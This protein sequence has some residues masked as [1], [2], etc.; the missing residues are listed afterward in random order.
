LNSNIIGG[1]LSS[2]NPTLSYQV[3]DLIKLPIASFKEKSKV[4]IS[5]NVTQNIVISKLDW[6]SSETSWDFAENPLVAIMKQA[7]GEE[8]IV[9]LEETDGSKQGSQWFATE[10]PMV[11]QQETEGFAAEKRHA[12]AADAT[13]ASLQQPCNDITKPLYNDYNALV[14]SLQGLCNPVDGVTTHGSTL[15]LCVKAFEKLWTA[16]FMQLHANEEELNRQFIDIYGLQDELT[17]DVPLNE[18]TILQQG[19]ISIE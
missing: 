17:P 6:D 18:I 2:I 3:A 11:S 4:T 1:I 7:E 12:E 15:E 16:R 13:D 8:P 19:E 5:L 14:N 9:S 10:K